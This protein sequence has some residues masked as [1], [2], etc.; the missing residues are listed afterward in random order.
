M[1]KLGRLFRINAGLSIVER[2][3][4]GLFERG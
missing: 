4:A 3:K 2:P 1:Q